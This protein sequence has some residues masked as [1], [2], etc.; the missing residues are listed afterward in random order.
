MAMVDSHV[1]LGE[2]VRRERKRQKLTQEQLAAFSGVG[3]RFVREL[4]KGKGTCQLGLVFAV[5]QALGLQVS[6]TSRGE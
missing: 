2:V 4:E 6:V 3:P 1:T 5:M